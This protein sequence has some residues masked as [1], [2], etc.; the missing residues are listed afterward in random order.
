MPII[1]VEK[2][3]IKLKRPLID[4]PKPEFR[5]GLLKSPTLDWLPVAIEGDEIIPEVAATAPIDGVEI[6]KWMQEAAAYN[7]VLDGMCE[8]YARAG[9][10][11]FS[12]VGD[13]LIP[14]V[15]VG[16]GAK[17]V[18]FTSVTA[19]TVAGQ[20][21]A[22]AVAGGQR[23]F[24]PEYGKL[25]M[26]TSDLLAWAAIP[27]RYSYQWVAALL[28]WVDLANSPIS[29]RIRFGSI[30]GLAAPNF[31]VVSSSIPPPAMM[32]TMGFTS[33]KPQKV[34]MQMRAA[35]D[36]TSILSSDTIEIPAG[37][38]EVSYFILGL[39]V[40]NSFLLELQPQD[41]TQTVLDKLEV[42]PP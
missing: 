27:G 2:R 22:Y 11:L 30:S 25:T 10:L 1:R 41:N 31:V 8:E 14:G 12:R 20:R 29:E 17:A 37:E 7:A 36:Y 24:V 13:G 5:R 6:V 18:R 40:V 19:T 15:G 42:T 9:S 34:G 21:G 28:N 4:L 16:S 3:E 39:P 23:F 26:I 32:M 38:S 33:D 35:G